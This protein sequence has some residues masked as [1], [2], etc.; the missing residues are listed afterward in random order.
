MIIAFQCT[1][2]EQEL[3]GLAAVPYGWISLVRLGSKLNI[4]FEHQDDNLPKM[5]NTSVA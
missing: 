1:E 2:A 3:T 5:E 4:E